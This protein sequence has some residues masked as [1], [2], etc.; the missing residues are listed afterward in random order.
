MQSDDENYNNNAFAG[1]RISYKAGESVSNTISCCF[2][3]ANLNSVAHPPP[4]QQEIN[5][6]NYFSL[7]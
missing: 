6:K 1:S 2:V 4:I 5:D 7:K 3:C